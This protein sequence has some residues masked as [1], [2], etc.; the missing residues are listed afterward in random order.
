MVFP[1]GS[2]HLESRDP[3]VGVNFDDKLLIGPA[4]VVKRFGEIC[5]HQSDDETA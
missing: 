4:A 1:W 2:Q 5:P 3:F